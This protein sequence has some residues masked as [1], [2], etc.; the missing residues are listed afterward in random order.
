MPFKLAKPNKLNKP[1]NSYLYEKNII[2]KKEKIQS[3]PK[4]NTPKKGHSF[5]V[6]DDRN[7]SIEIKKKTHNRRSENIS[8]IIEFHKVSPN[9]FRGKGENSPSIDH[10]SNE[11]PNDDFE[12]SSKN[13]NKLGIKKRLQALVKN[14]E[15]KRT[16]YFN[17]LSSDGCKVKGESPSIDALNET[18]TKSNEDR[19]PSSKSRNKLAIKKRLEAVVKNCEKKRTRKANASMSL[20]NSIEFDYSMRRNCKLRRKRGKKKDVSYENTK[21]SHSFNNNQ[22]IKLK[23]IDKSELVMKRLQSPN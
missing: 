3:R 23:V 14:C 18:G 8:R 20:G 16:V 6:M 15:K 1:S 7:K 9:D 17:K 2:T 21:I 12:I 5:F 19:E 11:S 10:Y 13:R 22:H 4:P